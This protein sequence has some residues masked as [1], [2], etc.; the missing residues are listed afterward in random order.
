[1]RLVKRGPPSG[2]R[3]RVRGGSPRVSTAARRRAFRSSGNGLAPGPCSTRTSMRDAYAP[4]MKLTRDALAGDSLEKERRRG[5]RLVAHAHRPCE[6]RRAGVETSPGGAMQLRERF[7]RA[8]LVAPA[9]A[10]EQP[11]R[12]VHPI[13]LARAP[14]SQLHGCQADL[15]RVERREE[16]RALRAHVAA[17]SRLWK[18]PRILHAARV[19]LLRLD[20]LGELAQGAPVGEDGRE[21]L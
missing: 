5:R 17:H 1:R 6:A 2:R 13:L 18:A 16:P 4:P 11:R 15:L 7:P 9:L 19:A 10:Q 3:C 21:L 12:G 20:D 8:D 14:G